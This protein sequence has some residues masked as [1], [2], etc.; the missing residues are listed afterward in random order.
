MFFL[1]FLNNHNR[2]YHGTATVLWFGVSAVLMLNREGTCFR[3]KQLLFSELR[4]CGVPSFGANS[5]LSELKVTSDEVHSKE[6]G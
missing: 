5:S 2:V 1:L 6:D 4:D 3:N